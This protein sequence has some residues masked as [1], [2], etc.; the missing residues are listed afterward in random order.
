MLR[1]GK[2]KIT[3]ERFYAAKKPISIWDV[4]LDNILISKLIETETNSQYLSEY[5]DKVITPLAF[6]LP[7]MSAYVKPFKVKG[8]TNS[9]IYFHIND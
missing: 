2:L 5:L 9:L 1:F 6:I 7:K 3:K 8:K 4:N